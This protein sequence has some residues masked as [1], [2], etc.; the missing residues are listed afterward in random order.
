MATPQQIANAWAA[1]HARHGGKLGPGPG[2]VE[3]INAA[4]STP[5]EPV[6]VDTLPPVDHVELV[7][8]LRLAASSIRT[9][10]PETLPANEQGQVHFARAL[11]E[12]AAEAIEAY[13]AA[14]NAYEQPPVPDV[15]GGEPVA[16][17]HPTAGWA[18]ANYHQVRNHCFNDG[19]MPVPLYRAAATEA[20][21]G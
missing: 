6:G 16:W 13:L 3:A 5:P 9:W 8:D 14:L 18:H 4:L 12:S 21:H 2:F 20:D 11:A 15:A 19:P 10:M 7:E 17:L 1:W